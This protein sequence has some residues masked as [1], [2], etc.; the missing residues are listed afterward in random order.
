M[1]DAE[2]RA[3]SRRLTIV[4]AEI[5]QWL[6]G[7]SLDGI[8]AGHAIYARRV[9][10]LHDRFGNQLC[11]RADCGFCG[12]RVSFPFAIGKIDRHLRSEHG[13]QVL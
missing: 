2:V 9:S 8:P 4:L 5:V 1:I 6:E 12:Y 13:G 10:W 7:K 11:V 3:V